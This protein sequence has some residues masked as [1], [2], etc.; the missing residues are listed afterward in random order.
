MPRPRF[1]RMPAD[2][3]D[4]LLHESAR[5][6]GEH[7]FDGASMNH[8]LEAAGVSKGAAYYYFDD[9]ADLLAAVVDHIWEHLLSD[10]HLDADRLTADDFWDRLADLSRTALRRAA[11]TPWM[12]GVTRAVWSL[13]PTARSEGPLAEVFRRTQTFLQGLL[14]RGRALGVVRDDLPLDLLMSMMLAMDEATD[15]WLAVHLQDLDEA[16]AEALFRRLFATLH[17]LLEPLPEETR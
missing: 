14:E 15:R 3:R 8:I 11:D 16:D 5:E 17:R 13:P 10:A 9:K 4:R 2:R 12:G 7:G 6:F 1:Y